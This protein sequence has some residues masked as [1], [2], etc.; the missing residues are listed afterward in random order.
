MNAVVVD[1]NVVHLEVGLL[2]RFLIR[3]FDESVLK[4]VASRLISN[5]FAADD[6]AELGK[7]GLQV[8]VHRDWIELA[9]E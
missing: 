8:L 7:D 2:A 4:T 6:L 3:I 5:D 9:D 1:K